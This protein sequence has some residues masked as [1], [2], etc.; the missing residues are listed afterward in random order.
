HREVLTAVDNRKREH[1]GGKG[2]S[3]YISQAHTFEGTGEKWKEHP[4]KLQVDEYPRTYFRN[5]T[6]KGQVVRY[7]PSEPNMAAGGLWIDWCGKNDGGEGNGQFTKNGK[8]LDTDLVKLVE[9]LKGRKI[10]GKG[11]DDPETVYETWSLVYLWAN[12]LM[13]FDWKRSGLKMEPSKGNSWGPLDQPSLASSNC[14]HR[15]GSSTP[16][17]IDAPN[18]GIFLNQISAKGA[19]LK[20]HPEIKVG[21]GKSG[22]PGGPKSEYSDDVKGANKA[23]KLGDPA[24]TRRRRRSFEVSSNGL[25]GIRDIDFNITRRLTD[26][27]LNNNIEVI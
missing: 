7:L 22:N 9:K 27:E 14:P 15:S 5:D 10:T 24:N 17:T 4:P 26:E 19:W 1:N 8:D 13:V 23:Q 11:K 21:G 20:K 2:R 18:M 3:D 6:N 25:F 12:F 16:R